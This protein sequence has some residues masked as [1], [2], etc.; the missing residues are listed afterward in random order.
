MAFLHPTPP[1]ARLSRV[2]FSVAVEGLALRACTLCSPFSGAATPPL[3]PS[4]TFVSA[5]QGEPSTH[6][7][8]F[9]RLPQGRL[10]SA[11]LPISRVAEPPLVSSWIPSP[12]RFDGGVEELV[13]LGVEDQSDAVDGLGGGEIGQVVAA[14]ADLR[15]GLLGRAADL[16]LKD[17]D[18]PKGIGYEVGTPLRLSVLGANKKPQMFLRFARK[19][20]GNSQILAD[21]GRAT[22]RRTA[23]ASLEITKG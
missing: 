20:F 4:C 22:A 3:G 21:L 15:E 16:E 12:H 7:H 11:N 6:S 14:I 17:E 23:R 13:G 1:V 10:Q 9:A 8:R 2:P 19:T 5:P 18:A